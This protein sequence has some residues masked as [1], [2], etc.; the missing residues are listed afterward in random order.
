MVL[1][2]RRVCAIKIQRWFLNQVDFFRKVWKSING[3]QALARGYIQRQSY[4]R[5]LQ[6]RVSSPPRQPLDPLLAV[7]K[8]QSWI[9]SAIIRKAYLY[10]HRLRFS[11]TDAQWN[12]K[13]EDVRSRILALAPDLSP[14]TSQGDSAQPGAATDYFSTDS[15]TAIIPTPSKANAVTARPSPASLATAALTDLE[16]T[17]CEA[18]DKSASTIPDYCYDGEDMYSLD[19][20]VV[21]E[22]KDDRGYGKDIHLITDPDSPDGSKR[23]LFSSINGHPDEDNRWVDPETFSRSWFDPDSSVATN[24]ERNQRELP[25]V[26]RNTAEQTSEQFA[27][28]SDDLLESAWD[29]QGKDDSLD[30]D[31]TMSDKI[32]LLQRKSK[33][34]RLRGKLSSSR[35]GSSSNLDSAA[36]VG[37]QVSHSSIRSRPSSTGQYGSA[38]SSQ[39]T[40]L[41]GNISSSAPPTMS[42]TASSQQ[43]SPSRSNASSKEYEDPPLYMNMS[44]ESADDDDIPESLHIFGA[45]M[46]TGRPPIAAPSHN[47]AI[48]SPPINPLAQHRNSGLQTVSQAAS[49]VNDIPM[50]NAS[51]PQS[52][53][54]NQQQRNRRDSADTSNTT[55][56]SL[57]EPFDVRHSAGVVEQ[58]KNAAGSPDFFV[59]Q[60]A[61]TAR[62]EFF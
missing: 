62:E 49:Y 43:G 46:T 53:N 44:T 16:A 30:E 37:S 61:D 39:V 40:E 8:I 54:A 33:L 59:Q 12:I 29:R 35:F 56:S 11:Y 10:E 31:T 3:F 23:I 6:Q 42:A 19:A 58:T 52:I 41:H 21:F 50:R 57:E 4:K 17:L 5:L 7:I 13:K 36:S 38:A 22:D 55:S 47:Q 32:S 18:R 9:R 1:A 51:R 20:P 27:A 26:D 60:Q 2:V 45:R 15:P 34:K 24:K 25:P 28:T 14:S 48:E